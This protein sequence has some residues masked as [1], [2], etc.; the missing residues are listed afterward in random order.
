MLYI[1]GKRVF[2]FRSEGLDG[3]SRILSAV[4]YIEISG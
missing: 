1:A 3:M 2:F 4:F